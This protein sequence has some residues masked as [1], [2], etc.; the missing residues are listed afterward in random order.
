MC[1]HEEELISRITVVRGVEDLARSQY[2]GMGIDKKTYTIMAYQG[3][4]AKTEFRV[5][6]NPTG[7]SWSSTHF[8]E[9]M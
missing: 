1:T 3:F 9:N 5:S 4:E 2:S 6:L 7:E 8:W